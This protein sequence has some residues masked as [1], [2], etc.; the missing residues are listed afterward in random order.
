VK[1]A[2]DIVI[3][4]PYYTNA[5]AKQRRYTHERH[6]SIVNLLY[7]ILRTRTVVKFETMVSGIQKIITERQR[8]EVQPRD[9]FCYKKLHFPTFVSVS[10]CS[11]YATKNCIR[12]LLPLHHLLLVD[13]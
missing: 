4:T 7:V 11:D 2:T 6:A 12:R 3:I 9:S 1:N 10:V 5:V 13:V 8:T